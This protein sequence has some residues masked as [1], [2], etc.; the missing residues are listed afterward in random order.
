MPGAGK[1]G[2]L[3]S[4]LK[5]KYSLLEK[6]FSKSPQYPGGGNYTHEEMIKNAN[7]VMFPAVQQGDPGQFPN[8][9]KLDFADAPKMTDVK[10]STV[11]NLK[12]W[13]ST[14]YTPNQVSPGAD[15]AAVGDNIAVNVNPMKQEDPA[16][17]VYD[18]KPTIV[19]GQNGT[20]DPSLTSD[21]MVDNEKGVL[22]SDSETLVP[23]KS[24]AN[25]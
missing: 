5:K 14:P 8:G 24:D 17:S 22:S 13:P 10:T 11:E 6:L 7:K 1:F 19:L 21:K 16:L 23:G 25:K 3:Y 15:P 12:G 20:V 2:T 9:V 4:R 18:I